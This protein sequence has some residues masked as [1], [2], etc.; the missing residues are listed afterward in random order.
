MLRGQMS[1]LICELRACFGT[2]NVCHNNTHQ[3]HVKYSL[4]QTDLSFIDC[5]PLFFLLLL[6]L[7]PHFVAVPLDTP[8]TLISALCV[9]Q[10]GSIDKL[11]A[12]KSIRHTITNKIKKRERLHRLKIELREYTENKKKKAPNWRKY[13]KTVGFFDQWWLLCLFRGCVCVRICAGKW[14][15]NTR[16]H[17]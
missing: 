3:N 8:F 13:N 7:L 16:I 11:F 4:W 5:F 14:G 12:Q 1:H 6:L 10:S 2:R 9:F 15:H 17:K